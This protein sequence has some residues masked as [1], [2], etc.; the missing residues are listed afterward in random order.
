MKFLILA[1]FVAAATA[2][3]LSHDDAQKVKDS[4]HKVNHNEADILYN[5][6]HDYP[7]HQSRFPAFVGKDL[8]SLKDTAKFAT[9][10]TRIVSALSE[11]IDFGGDPAVRPA[12]LTVLHTLGSDHHRRGVPK[13]SFNDFRTSLFKYL[14]AHDDAWNH[15]LEETW[16]HAIDNCYAVL[17]EQYN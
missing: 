12:L 16:G 15:D 10:A 2:A 17:F 7:Q 13:E 5:F 6:F 9:H 1:L 8:D 14:K 11:V 3:P 4:W